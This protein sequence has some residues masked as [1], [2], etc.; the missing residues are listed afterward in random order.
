MYKDRKCDG[1]TTNTP[2][3]K[4]EYQRIYLRIARSNVEEKHTLKTALFETLKLHF[5][6]EALEAEYQ[7][8]SQTG[9]PITVNPEFKL[10]EYDLK[11]IHSAVSA[12]SKGA[13]QS[14]VETVPIDIPKINTLDTLIPFYQDIAVEFYARYN[15]LKLEQIENA[16]KRFQGL[17]TS[18]LEQVNQS[19]AKLKETMIFHRIMQEYFAALHILDESLRLKES[20]ANLKQ[21]GDTAE[22]QTKLWLLCMEKLFSEGYSY[23][24]ANLASNRVV[25]RAI[26]VASTT[27]PSNLKEI[28]DST[29]QK[30]VSNFFAVETTK[31]YT[32]RAVEGFEC[33][34]IVGQDS[35]ITHL[36][37]AI[38]VKA[39]NEQIREQL[40]YERWRREVKE[41]LTELI[42][43][44]YWSDYVKHECAKANYSP[45]RLKVVLEMYEQLTKDYLVMRLGT[46]F[47]EPEKTVTIES[48][49]DSDQGNKE[50]TKQ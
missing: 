10:Q 31:T 24:E 39:R 37:E 20:W 15:T 21:Y 42:Q 14:C 6:T 30:E 1:M 9:K 3:G 11:V 22:N 34:K 41:W 7:L 2:D 33:W 48:V 36:K 40:D 32:S 43:N 12:V 35:T 27:L 18:E 23:F 47:K 46:R 8:R 26:S 50:E 17:T 44:G 25:E 38:Y 4:R 49:S 19:L 5:E 16:V 45:E 28:P 13:P 29:P